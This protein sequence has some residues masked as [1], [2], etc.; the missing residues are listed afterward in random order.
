MRSTES[1][2]AQARLTYDTCHAHSDVTPSSDVICYLLS[3]ILLEARRCLESPSVAQ[4]VPYCDWMSALGHTDQ[5]LARGQEPGGGGKGDRKT[6]GDIRTGAVCGDR[7][8]L[9]G[10]NVYTR[11]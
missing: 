10:H 7:R 5:E 8:L 6:S 2:Q 3:V 11:G 4:L 1:A 9:P